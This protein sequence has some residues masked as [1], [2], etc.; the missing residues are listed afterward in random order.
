[1]LY[2][3]LGQALEQSGVSRDCLWGITDPDRGLVESL[4]KQKEWIDVVVPRGGDS[5]IDFVTR[6]SR[7]PIIKND[8]GLCHV[9]V[10]EDADLKMAEEIVDNAKTQRPGVCNA[11]ET[12]LVHE[13]VA[14]SFLPALHRRLASRA[15]SGSCVPEASASST[16]CGSGACAAPELGHRVPESSD[17][18]SGGFLARG[19]DCSYRRAWLA[20]FGSD[21]D[22]LGASCPAL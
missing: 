6:N 5:L 1:M 16:G 11:M 18:L 8:R 3:I 13:S 14:P 17:E 2:E 4:L 12:L 15:F 9:Y 21:R 20:A 19:G 10:H 22:S 7:I